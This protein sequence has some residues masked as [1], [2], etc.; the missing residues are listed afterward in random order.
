[1]RLEEE[2]GDEP[3]PA[4]AGLNRF[5][6]DMTLAPARSFPGM[7]LW[8][9]QPLPPP[10]VPGTY[11]V[12]LSLG[13]LTATAP[14]TIEKD[15]RSAA[16]ADDLAAQ[17]R[18][19][20]AIRTKL[21]ETHDALSR[22]RDVRA[23]L[24]DLGKRL[25]RYD[26]TDRFAK[27]REASRALTAKLQ[28]VEESLYQTKNR[29]LEDPLNFPVRLNDK[30]NAVANSAALGDSRPTAQAVAVQEELTAAIDAQLAKLRQ[31]WEQDLP[32]FDELARQE[33]VTAVLPPLPQLK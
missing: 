7:I 4:E 16:T 19:L 23:Q 6:W 5:V 15:P 33:G 2:P 27:L 26:E 28:A 17:Q 20:L 30:L 22:L 3:V 1:Q 25:S 32:A 14:F 12:R 24:E 9:G 29:S 8:S 31:I 10:A 21:G 18:F 13:G 11:Q